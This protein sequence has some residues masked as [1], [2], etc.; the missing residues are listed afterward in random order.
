MPS[1]KPRKT[2]RAEAK[3]PI[4]DDAV[5]FI[6]QYGSAFAKLKIRGHYEIHPIESREFRR[7]AISWLMGRGRYSPNRLKSLQDT[8]EGL[9][10]MSGQVHPLYVRVAKSEDGAFW[11]DLVNSKWE[12][13]RI[14]K[15][16]WEVVK[17]PPILFRRYAHMKEIRVAA[18]G[19]KDD[20]DAFIGTLNLSGEDDVLLFKVHLVT[21]IIPGIPHPILT[22]VGAQGSAKSSLCEAERRVIDN[23]EIL[24]LSIPNDRGELA[25][26]LQ[27]HWFP[28]FDNCH[29]LQGWQS[30]MLCRA[31]TGEGFPKR[32]LY[33]DEEDIV[34]KYMR[35]VI[36]NGIN[37]PGAAPDLLDRSLLLYL[38]RLPKIRRK[39]KE[40]ITARQEELSPRVLAYI[41]DVLVQALRLLDTVP[42]TNLPRMADFA[43]YGEAVARAAGYTNGEFLEVYNEN[44]GKQTYEA[45]EG[46]LLGGIVL[47]FMQ[48]HIVWEGTPTELL[49]ELTSL[50]ETQRINTKDYDF[51]KGA[52]SLTR[53]LNVLKANLME[54]GIIY[55]KRHSGE[56]FISLVKAE[57]QSKSSG[58]SRDADSDHAKKASKKTNDDVG[59]SDN[60]DGIPQGGV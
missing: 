1:T 55:N 32:K 19:A 37:T 40:D 56:N 17:A 8:C 59:R 12:A 45:I 50:A 18:K 21:G 35:V 52:N 4:P 13:V 39:R 44:I 22:P 33:T 58:S 25:Q 5:F 23:S 20:M 49:V 30:D 53:K 38:E 14:T 29:C 6:D 51:P 28:V 16:G 27:H 43:W 9:A 41:L 3:M 47:K 31:C 7:M 42:D 46:S 15:D 54:M 34:F 26:L 24:L 60:M 36:L 11:L 10:F 48:N 2:D 57:E